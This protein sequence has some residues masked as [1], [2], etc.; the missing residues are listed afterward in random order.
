MNEPRTCPA[1]VSNVFE[2]SSVTVVNIHLEEFGVNTG[3]G[4]G[5]AASLINAL[6]SK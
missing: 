6:V 2:T 1:L 5:S 4:A 3:F